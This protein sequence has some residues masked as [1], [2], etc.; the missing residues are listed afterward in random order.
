M[1]T[2]VGAERFRV[3]RVRLGVRRRDLFRNG[4]GIS[5]SL[6]LSAACRYW[7]ATTETRLLSIQD[8]QHCLLERVTW[9]WPSVFVPMQHS[10]VT[11][12]WELRKIGNPNIVP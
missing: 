4:D 1:Y 11:P 2:E 6:H 7:Q 8:D 3:F 5:M 9:I 10:P 12:M